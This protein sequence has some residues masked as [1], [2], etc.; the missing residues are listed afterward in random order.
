[1]ES[2][3]NAPIERHGGLFFDP[4]ILEIFTL[5]PLYVILLKGGGLLEM[6]PYW[7]IYGS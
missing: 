3:V 5:V 4:K 1:M 7:N 2:T 6:A